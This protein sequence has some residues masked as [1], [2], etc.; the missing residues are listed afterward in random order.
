MAFFNKFQKVG[1]DI[2]GIPSSPQFTPV[3]NILQ[4]TRLKTF[5]LN[6]QIFFQKYLVKDGETPEILADQFYGDPELHWVLLYAQQ[7]TNPYYDWPMSYFDLVKFA[8]AKYGFAGLTEVHHY[9]DSDGF[10]VDSDAS[11]AQPVTNKEYEEKI[12]DK[13]R[14]IELIRP[15][16]I[17]RI[18]KEMKELLR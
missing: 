13:N 5:F 7:V 18:L 16:N 1:Y 17:N 9:E 14:Q 3:I 8:T 2:K 6:R 10:V 4:R 15:E 12:N 11:G